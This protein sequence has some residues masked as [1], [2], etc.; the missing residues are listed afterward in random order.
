MITS[1]SCHCGNI[2]FTL[3][4]RDAPARIATRACTCSFCRKHGGV[5]T[6][7]P[8]G[9]LEV[10]VKDPARVGAYAFGTQTARFHVCAVCGVVP[11]V[12]SD[13]GGRLRAVVNVNAFDG[14][15]ASLIE[16]AAAACFDAESTDE[17]LAR[18][19]R[20]W[21]PDVVFRPG[22]PA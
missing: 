6:S 7:C 9:A 16:P 4:W 14:V 3:D 22:L 18:R 17:R 10:T 13:A 11:V 20:N 19:E 2:S 12:T 1:G 8:T 5:W 15:D 21:I